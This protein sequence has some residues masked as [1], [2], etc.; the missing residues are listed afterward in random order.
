M[1]RGPGRT[2]AA[3]GLALAVAASLAGRAHAGEL[4]FEDFE[5]FSAIRTTRQQIVDEVDRIV[6]ARNARIG[7]IL[8]IV[9]GLGALALA[10]NGMFNDVAGR[11]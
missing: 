4:T 6:S 5:R 11:L 3:A 8:G 9:V 10:L 2:V 1:P 7:N